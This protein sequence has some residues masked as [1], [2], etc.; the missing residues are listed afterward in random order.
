M[1]AKQKKAQNRTNEMNPFGTNDFKFRL[2]KKWR[3][4]YEKQY[5][6][7]AF[8]KGVLDLIL[9]LTDNL[10]KVINFFESQFFSFFGCTG[11]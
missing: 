9:T 8:M 4:E 5:I 7:T 11:V 2:T 3:K 6:M 1:E 10:G